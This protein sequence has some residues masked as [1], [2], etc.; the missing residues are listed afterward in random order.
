VHVIETRPDLTSML[1]D[2][3]AREGRELRARARFCEGPAY[4][5]ERVMAGE[6]YEL[7]LLSWQ[8]GQITPIHDHGGAHSVSAVLVGEMLEEQFA[9]VSGLDV[10]CTARAIRRAGDV[11]A[12]DPTAIHRVHPLGRVIT[13]HLYAP[14]CRDGQLFRALEAA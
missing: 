6:G 8:P 7:W 9:R 2:F 12:I 11:D 13:L 14:G 3:L 1:G 10:R 5:R 4:A